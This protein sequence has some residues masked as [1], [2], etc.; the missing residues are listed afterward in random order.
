VRAPI[1][2]GLSFMVKQFPSSITAAA[3]VRQYA[4]RGENGAHLATRN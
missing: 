4:E 1:D 3:R 2:D